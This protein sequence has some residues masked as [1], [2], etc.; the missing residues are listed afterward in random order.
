MM[1]LDG[2]IAG[3]P[4]AELHVHI[5]GTLEPELLFALAARNGIA[6][7]Y[8]SVQALR[9]AYDF[10]SLQ[11][12][13]DLYYQGMAVLKSEQDYCD[14]AMAYV[15]RAAADGVRHAEVFFD[16]QAH[17]RNGVPL[18]TVLAGLRRATEASVREHGLSLRLILCFLRDLGPDDAMATL[19]AALP[20]RDGFIGVGLDS[21]E[22]GNPPGPFAPVFARARAAGLRTVAHAGEEGPA[23]YVRDALD[24]LHAER[25]EHGV[26][27]LE[28]PALVARLAD[29]GVPITVCP[30]SN[31]RLSV[32]GSMAEHPLPRMLE[33][34][35]TVTINSDDPAY[36]GSY[37]N[38]NY[39]ACAVAFGLGA[40]ALADLARASF[41]ASFI[42]QA[43]KAAHMADIDSWCA[44]AA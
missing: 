13:L 17:A 34:G 40:D 11:D 12:F 15:R 44:A 27:A 23:D 37:I 5:E 9:A 43:K 26:R 25:I 7:P 32:V 38:D 8:A 2:F 29:Q 21:A 10:A 20:H 39:R 42:S 16:P 6:V 33:Q 4:K 31:V 35:L 28:D 22:Q 14:L 36:F 41:R 19:E 3:L 30:L 24:L 18:T 1:D